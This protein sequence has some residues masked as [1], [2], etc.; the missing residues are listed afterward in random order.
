[1]IVGR[2]NDEER[3]TLAEL[4]KALN[5]DRF[6]LYRQEIRQ[7]PAP[8]D[9]PWQ[10]ILIRF[11]DEDDGMLPP[12]TFFEVLERS[13]MMTLLDRWVI[14]RLLRWMLARS[15]NNG[16]GMPQRS[17]VNLSNESLVSGDFAGYVA[18]QLTRGGIAGERIAFEIP[19]TNAIR[20]A[21]ALEKLTA[22]LKPAGCGFLLSGYTGRHLSARMLHAI[23]IDGVKLHGR[24]VQHAHSETECLDTAASIA[25][26]CQGWGLKIIAEFVELPETL[27]IF[28][29]MGVDY[30]QGW[31]VGVPEPL[32]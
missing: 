6:V 15:R 1:M 22:A 4:I 21:V 31:G 28:T 23:G 19:E 18:E 2:Q 7:V 8:R 9:S 24:I 3:R 30:V 27:A 12:G 29:A 25:G 14:N 26:A 32:L 20:H 11:Q 10:E 16:S 5:G 13:H 17:T